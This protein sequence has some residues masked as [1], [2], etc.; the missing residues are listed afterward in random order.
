MKSLIDK[1]N[2]F[3]NT[4]QTVELF[5]LLFEKCPIVGHSPNSFVEIGAPCSPETL[6]ELKIGDTTIR[7]E[8]IPTA[9]LIDEEFLTT[10]EWIEKRTSISEEVKRRKEMGLPTHKDKNGNYKE[11]F[12]KRI[13][14]ELNSTNTVLTQQEMQLLPSHY[15][16]LQ[17]LRGCESQLHVPRD[18]AAK[19]NISERSLRDNLK[20]MEEFGIVKIKVIPEQH[21]TKITVKENWA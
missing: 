20:K 18:I 12:T 13:S 2:Q 16:I 11:Q 3:E 6:R 9:H 15:F 1:I 8:F 21:G 19:L 10:E 14:A 7:H 17:Y 4:S 5:N